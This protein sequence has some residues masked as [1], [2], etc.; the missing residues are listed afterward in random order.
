MIAQETPNPKI[1]TRIKIPPTEQSE[2]IP[3]CVHLQVMARKCE[4]KAVAYSKA[5]A[6]R[7]MLGM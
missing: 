4:W 3:F 6:V 5:D 2:R 1:G 7:A